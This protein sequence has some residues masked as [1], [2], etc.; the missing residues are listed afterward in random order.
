MLAK[1]ALTVFLS[2]LL[3]YPGWATPNATA[4]GN[5]TDSTSASVRGSNLTPGSTL[6]AGDAVEVGPNG[7]AMIALRGGSQLHMGQNSQVRL[8]KAADRIQVIVDRGT[9]S[10]RT[11]QKAPAEAL[12]ADASIRSADGSP[13][14]GIVSVRSPELALIA[15]EK[16]TLLVSTAHD[17]KS[18]TVREGEGVELKLVAVDPDQR[19]GAPVPAGYWSATKIIILAIILGAATT[20]IGLWLAHRETEI[21]VNQRCNEISPFRCF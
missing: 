9:T 20:A 4:I 19:G 13:A 21:P 6:F 10:F 3:A 14:I 16:G 1:Q 17:S 18:V 2:L 15:A 8:A 7:S 11:D 5:V 12:L